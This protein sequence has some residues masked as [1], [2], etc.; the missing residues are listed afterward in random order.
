MLSS[1][2]SI[3]GEVGNWKEWF[4]VAESETIDE[5]MKK[6]GESKLKIRYQINI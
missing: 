6:L 5:V 1:Y 4:T 2:H 3:S